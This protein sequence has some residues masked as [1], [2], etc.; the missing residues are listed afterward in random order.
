MKDISI[1]E[2][3][4]NVSLFS[5]GR[6]RPKLVL[7]AQTNPKKMTDLVDFYPLG[8]KKVVTLSETGE[9]QLHGFLGTLLDTF[10]IQPVVSNSNQTEDGDDA[11]RLGAKFRRYMM[12]ITSDLKQV[13]VASSCQGHYRESITLLEI[14]GNSR[15]LKLR[16]LASLDVWN[17]TPG[18]ELSAL[19]FW[20]LENCGI[21]ADLFDKEEKVNEDNMY[22]F[23]VGEEDLKPQKR[24]IY[25]I[26]RGLRNKRNIVSFFFDGKKLEPFKSDFSCNHSILYTKQLFEVENALVCIDRK[27]RLNH[28]SLR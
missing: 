10:K 17:G 22:T 2:I 26:E 21:E 12:S 19:S 9:V 6:M 23:G 5:V 13:L 27:A 1:N 28:I 16:K 14:F 15:S 20:P 24:I 11:A 8:N 4:D 18:S 25:G 3:G 7:T